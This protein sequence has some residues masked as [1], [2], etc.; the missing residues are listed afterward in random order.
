MLDENSHGKG[1]NSQVKNYDTVAGA[2]LLAFVERVERMRKE[3]KS[4]GEDISEVFGE[5]KGE[6]YDVKIVKEVL[7]LREMESGAR[8]ERDA[9]LDLYL[10][11]LGMV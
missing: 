8:H 3:R 10:N 1:H 4:I 7:K 9:V 2:K 5:M 6:G 11:A